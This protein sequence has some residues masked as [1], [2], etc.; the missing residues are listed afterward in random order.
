MAKNPTED[1]TQQYGNLVPTGRLREGKPRSIL[2]DATKCIGC[3]H[4]VQACKDWND[5]A[6]TTLYELSSTNWITI[7]PPVLE[8]TPPP[9]AAHQLLALRLSCLRRGLPCRSD[10]QV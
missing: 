9:A 3:R 2:F 7:E 6:R 8:R 1:L 5:H 4:C 10:H